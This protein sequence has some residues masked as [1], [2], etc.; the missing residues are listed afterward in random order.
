MSAPRLFE[1]IRLRGV[2]VRNR[3][4]VAPMCQY[5][6]DD[7]VVGRWHL[8]HLGQ[9]AVGGAGVVMT[10]AT[11]VLPEGR[12]SPE[13]P[14]IWNDEQQDAWAPIVEVIRAHGAVP[15]IQLA[16][17]GRK[18][19]VFRPWADR[20]GTVPVEDGG[21]ETVAP[22]AIA[23]EGLGLPRE[24]T[25]AGIED[26]IEAFRD[27]AARA[28]AAGF[29]VVE[30]HAAHGY[31]LHEFLSPLSNR[32]TDAWGGDLAGR[33]RLTVETVRAVRAVVGDAV[34]VLVRLSAWD[35]ADGGLV[36][37]EVGRVAAWAVEA[38]AD[39]VDVTTGGITNHVEP[40]EPGY[41][42]EDAAVVKSVSG[43]TTAAVGR[44]DTGAIAEAALQAGQADV[45]MAGREWLRDPH[46][47]LRASV[48]LDADPALWP[49][50]YRRARG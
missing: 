1:P 28:V 31:L 45:V 4:W 49:P 15:G 6:A 44:L 17:A 23:H 47:A 36:P 21:W 33:A 16:H 27:A 20:R 24:L 32:R 10:E 19:S 39:L 50:Q 2:T 41:Q 12:I 26:V 37:A 14:G 40:L 38:G 8:V 46:Y 7:G 22:S 30:V 43:A 34:P 48:E 13:C 29:G 11:G 25:E 5:S 42:L 9:F 3:L 18:G 35:W